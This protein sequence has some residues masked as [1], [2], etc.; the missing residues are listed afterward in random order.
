MQCECSAWNM[1]VMGTFSNNPR[2]PCK[3]DPVKKGLRCGLT[4]ELNQLAFLFIFH[5][6]TS[7]MPYAVISTDAA[8]VGRYQKLSAFSSQK[9]EEY[10]LIM[11]EH[12]VNSVYVQQKEMQS[13]WNAPCDGG[14]VTCLALLSLSPYFRWG[15]GVLK[16]RKDEVTSDWNRGMTRIGSVNHMFLLVLKP[17]N[18]GC[19]PRC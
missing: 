18:I 6:K 8:S 19:C 15:T 12:Q 17:Q 14:R 9:S 2:S 11:F 16:K 13:G 10:W 1:N 4:A 3:T 7:M 5:T